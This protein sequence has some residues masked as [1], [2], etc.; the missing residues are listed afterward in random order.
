MSK[1]SFTWG[2]DMST[3]IGGGVIDWE[4]ECTVTYEAS[5]KYIPAKIHAPA[6][7]CHPAEYPEIEVIL[8]I[9]SQGEEACLIGDEENW[10]QKLA[11]EHY[12]SLGE[13]DYNEYGP[14]NPDYE[15]DKHRQQ[16]LDDEK[17]A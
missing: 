15:Y 16:E 3:D 2:R 9:D 11:E 8:V 1:H 4:D 14:G 7:D 6:E 10:V 17:G 12:D 5:G 13:P